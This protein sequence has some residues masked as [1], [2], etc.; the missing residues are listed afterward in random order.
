MRRHGRTVTVHTV[1][2]TPN[3]VVHRLPA[4]LSFA[5]GKLTRGAHTLRVVAVFHR[6]RDGHV[7]TVDKTLTRH[8]RVC[9]R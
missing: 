9:G 5:L 1:S 7:T 4:D 3:R 8:F 6:S 2:Y